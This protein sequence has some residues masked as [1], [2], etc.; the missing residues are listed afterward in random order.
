M[1]TA[2]VLKLG[3]VLALVLV[4]WRLIAS[5][6]IVRVPFLKDCM[7]QPQHVI[8]N[9]FRN[10]EPERLANRVLTDVRD[11]KCQSVLST[12]LDMDQERK[13]Y[14]CELFAEKQHPPLTSWTLKNRTDKTQAVQL[15]YLHHND[16]GI[17]MTIK[18]V[19]GDWKLSTVSAVY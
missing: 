1:K 14:M 4:G 8:F 11:G 10:R 5:P 7:N 16:E 19:N 17:W 2:T 3:G 12:A 15:Y 18:A 6:V 9:P 13:T